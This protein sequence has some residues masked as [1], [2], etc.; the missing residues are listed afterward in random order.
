[1]VES[2]RVGMDF[3]GVGMVAMALRQLHP[4]IDVRFVSEMSVPCQTFLRDN[5]NPLHVSG[6]ILK[7]NDK[8]TSSVYVLSSTPPRQDFSSEN[9][10]GKGPH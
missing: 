10:Q 9:A 4:R 6:D 3:A 8:K 2:L 5:F 1:M 7:R